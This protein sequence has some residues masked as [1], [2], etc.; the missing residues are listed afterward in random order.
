MFLILC[1]VTNLTIP[2]LIAASLLIPE[3]LLQ[4]LDLGGSESREVGFCECFSL[5]FLGGSVVKNL[6]ASAEDA[7][8]EEDAEDWFN[9]W[10]RKFP[11]RRAWQP[12]LVFLPGES[13][14]QRSL[15]GYSPWSH[16]ES[17]TAEHTQLR[18]CKV[19]RPVDRLLGLGFF[20]NTGNL[21]ELYVFA[22]TLWNTLKVL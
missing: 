12:I 21:S 2:H 4:L 8:E 18:I 9:P 14:G 6:P 3:L 1:Y 7:G 5:G 16:K 17:D 22:G 15:V 11:W 19:K 20:S 10:F 13:H